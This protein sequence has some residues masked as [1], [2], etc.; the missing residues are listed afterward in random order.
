MNPAHAL[1]HYSSKFLSVS[2]FDLYFILRSGVYPEE[3]ISS[4][5]LIYISHILAFTAQS[6][7]FADISY[8]QHII[9]L[10]SH[11]KFT[12]LYYE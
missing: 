4:I 5:I 1:S 9:M 12:S 11:I 2:Y 3:F 7:A 8:R 6:K 10:H